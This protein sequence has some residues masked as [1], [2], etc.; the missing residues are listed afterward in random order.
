MDIGADTAAV[1]ASIIL[2]NVLAWLTPGPNMLAV[3]SAAMAHGRRAGLMTGFGLA[4]AATIW[5]ALAMLGVAVLFD[6][7]P[8][9]ILGLKLVGAG[10]LIWLGF[11]SL[12]SACRPVDSDTVPEPAA[13]DRRAFITGFIVSISNPKAA[14]FFGSVLT[15]FV[16]A[17]ASDTFLIGTVL[18]CGALGVVLHSITA[19]VFS[20]GPA[21]RFFQHSRRR[22]ALCFGAV[23]SGLG[24][25]VAVDALRRG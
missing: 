24:L 6:L 1:L 7:F 2:V 15:A 20:T 25:I 4:A 21:M 5:A 9:V 19:T 10:Y 3:M 8:D 18:L 14:L 17:G 22:I 13:T 11:R 23:F 16:P 12:R